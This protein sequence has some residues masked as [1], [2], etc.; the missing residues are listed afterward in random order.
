[1]RV[2]PLLIYQPSE[3]SRIRLQYNLDR[4]DF[5]EDGD[6]AHGVWLGFEWLFGSHPAHS[7]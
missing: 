1:V 4:A 7:F 6:H 3:F 2:S 5:L